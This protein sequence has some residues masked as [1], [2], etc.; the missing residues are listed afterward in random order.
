MTGARVPVLLSTLLGF[1]AASVP[2]EP[3]YLTNVDSL[4]T[5]YS[6]AGIRV[7]QHVNRTNNLVAVSLYLLGGTRQIT[8]RTAGIE[9]L[10]LRAAANGTARYPDGLSQRAMSRTGSVEFLNPTV[11]W[12]VVGFVTLRPDVDSAWQVFADRLL[13][14]TL[15][16]QEV[17]LARDEMLATARQRYADPDERIHII[18]SRVT[19]VGHPYALHPDGTE[20]SLLSLK[21]QDLAD[22]AA[23]QTVKSRMLLVVSGNIERPQVESLVATTIGSLPPGQ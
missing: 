6:V 12:T 14:P 17:E 1:G 3:L 9:P 5:A 22:Y 21:Q 2:P 8:E 4:T 11:D 10:L 19:F 7:I 16:A 13:H 18:A 23:T 20:Q 15:A